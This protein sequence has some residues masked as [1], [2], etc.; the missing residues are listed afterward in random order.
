MLYHL[1][2][3][4]T[5]RDRVRESIL[6]VFSLVRYEVCTKLIITNAPCSLTS[7][8]ISS[9][10]LRGC[11]HRAYAKEWLNIGGARLLF[12]PFS[13]DLPSTSITTFLLTW[14]RST[15]MPMRFISLI[16]KTLFVNSVPIPR[17]LLSPLASARPS[18]IKR[19]FRR[20]S[21]VISG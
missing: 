7:R 13:G 18:I 14:E 4:R 3:R 19:S 8:R 17:S 21:P 20:R 10:T 9:V 11:G 16:R 2:H 6:V 12:Q 1:F 5:F 15:I